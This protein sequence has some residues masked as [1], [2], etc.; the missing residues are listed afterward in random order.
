MK[1]LRALAFAASLL[2]GFPV[3]AETPGQFRPKPFPN[4][5]E[6]VGATGKKAQPKDTYP[7]SR[8]PLPPEPVRKAKLT[9]KGAPVLRGN[10]LILNAGWEMAEAPNIKADGAALSTAGFDT[11]A[12]YDATVPGTA[13]ATLVDQGVYRDPYFGL[14]N[15]TIPE[16]LNKQDYWYRTEFSLP[17]SFSGRQLALQFKGINYYA[18]IWLNGHYLGHITGAFIRGDFDITKAAQ[19]GVNTLAVMIMPVPDPGLP[20]EQ[21]VKFG[22]GDNGGTGCLDGPTFVCSEG[23]DWIPALR[24]RCAGIWQ[25]VVVRA[26]GDVT[27]LDPH[28]I[29]KLPLP[30]TSKA[31]VSVEV[32]LANAS[33]SPQSGTLHGS[34]EGVSFDKTVTVPP[35]ETNLVRITPQEFAQL[36]VQNPRL[37]WPNGYGKPELYHLTLSF[38]NQSGQASDTREVRF[39]IREMSY[40]L[41]ATSGGAK[42]RFEY[43]PSAARGG[44]PVIDMR[45]KSM[46]WRTNGW[47]EEPVDPVIVPGQETSPALKALHDPEMT[48]YL[49]I[50]VNGQRI[51]CYGG[52]WGMDDAMKRISREKLE[53]YMRLHRDGNIVMIRNWSGQSTSETFYDLCDEYG[54]LV[55]NDFWMDTEGWNYAPIDHD[56]FLRNVADTIKRYRNH[57]SIAIWCAMNEGVPPNDINEGNDR[58]IRELDGTR[59]YQP[60]SRWVN[61]RMS[62]PWSNQPLDKYYHELNEGFST[63]MG[64]FSVPSSE[65]I[66]SMM[67]EADTW[68][69]GDVWAYHDLHSVGNGDSHTLIHAIDT[70]FG[71]ANSLDDF[72]RKSQMVNYETYRAIYEGFGA[73]LWKPSGG[74]LVWMSHPSWPSTV[75]QFYTW[76]YEPN[77]ALFGAKK[78]AEPIHIQMS[79]PDAKVTIVNHTAKP[80]E[81]VTATATIYSLTGK[82]EQT[83]PKKLTAAA[84]AATD[85]TTLSWPAHDA[86]FVRLTLADQAGQPLSDNFYW[87][88]REEGDLTQLTNLPNADVQL[89]FHF[90]NGAIVGEASTKADSAPAL[91]VRLLLRDP[92]TNQRILPAYYSDDY[93]DLM[94][95]EH[96][97]F[98]I[99]SQSAILP[100]AVIACDGWNIAPK[101]TAAE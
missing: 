51:M 9:E 42:K 41:E 67:D 39:G 19:P 79:L 23:W 22:P 95:G 88:A 50:K 70:R 77:A 61:L 5:T 81:H 14:N 93:F 84:N 58:L 66:R 62:G 56:L 71:P 25:D 15:L 47:K 34:F 55:W 65:V 40:E 17:A 54:L 3:W 57:P 16:S 12:W 44:Q 4:P 87:H 43:I 99:E 83:A 60:N 59:Y 21:S 30:D 1:H 72:T 28:V 73:R 20:S 10:E 7:K 78:G 80:L 26:S 38:T 36:T 69:L 52:N 24:D 53:P 89:K 98:R 75:W 85:V 46:H 18:E 49:A 94:P 68:P 96:R 11:K 90:E 101:T 64:A 76:D 82:V 35:G 91:A 13:L 33:S 97:S 92:K 32:E 2:L 45:R 37:W 31:D 100:T 8:A 27:L 6:K 63:E 86:H 48:R 74:V 29:T